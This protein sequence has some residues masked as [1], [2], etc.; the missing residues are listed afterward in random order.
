LPENKR[1]YPRLLAALAMFCH[2]RVW[3]ILSVALLLTA[4]CMQYITSHMAVSTDF[5]ALLSHKL[6]FARN[7][8]ALEK[9]FP[10]H[11]DTVLVVIDGD[12]ADVSAYAARTFTAW[13]SRH[14]HVTNQ[15]FDPGG[16][17]FFQRNGLL[18]LNPDELD[19]VSGRL[20]TMQPVLSQ[21]ARDTSLPGMTKLIGDAFD[22]DM[23][24]TPDKSVVLSLMFDAWRAAMSAVTQQRFF[25]FPW[26]DIM[27]GD[28]NIMAS[29]QHIIEVTPRMDAAAIQPA[30]QAIKAIQKA[31][32]ALGLTPDHG[33]RVRLTGS[34]M[35][36]YVQ[37]QG[38]MQAVGLAASLAGTLILLLLW[39]ALKSVRM[40][41][42]VTLTLVMSLIWTTAFALYA[43][44][45]LNIISISFAVLFIGMGV[46]FGIQFGMHC[47]RQSSRD[48]CAIAAIRHTASGQ[49]AAMTISATAAAAG[50]L[51]FTPTAYKGLADLGLIAGAGMALALAATLTVLPALMGWLHLPDTPHPVGASFDASEDGYSG[52]GHL[53]AWISAHARAITGA[54]IIIACM[55]LLPAMNLTF[56]F[57]P[58]HLLDAS[59]PAVKTFKDLARASKASPY[60]IEILAK[61]KSSAEKLA[62]SLRQQSSVA[63][64]VTLSSLIPEHQDEKLAAIEELT[65]L[66]PPFTLDVATYA[67]SSPV[68]IRAA[69]TRTARILDAYIRAHTD[70]SIA[71]H[72]EALSR[73]IRDFISHSSST[74]LLTLEKILMQGLIRQI[75]LLAVSL[76]PE[77][78][79]VDQLPQLLKQRFLTPGGGRLIQVYS[80]LNLDNPGNMERFVRQ[81]QRLAPQAS[82]DPVMMVAGGHAVALAFRQASVIAFVF[83]AILLAFSLKSVWYCIGVL[84]PLLLA[85]LLTAATMK[86][87]GISLNLANVIVAPLLAGLGVSYGIYMALRQRMEGVGGLFASATP[88]AILFSALTTL[89]SFGSMAISGDTAMTSLGVTLTIALS[90]VLVCVLI[91][92]PAL[93][94]LPS[95]F[96]PGRPGNP[97]VNVYPP[98]P[99]RQEAP[100]K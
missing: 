88:Q 20:I 78:I 15:F 55:A 28:A 85:T 8:A 46:D 50:F 41:L 30:A 74:R 66:L 89:C 58:L 12:T 99:A 54:S 86:I 24:D 7:H 65:M 70:S 97:C 25:V 11:N 57:N 31:I 5:D 48:I 40:L 43:T 96:I 77:T 68:A 23:F 79:T 56:D 76:S 19:A 61:N 47:R 18:Y 10:R 52:E 36:D 60:A 39:M 90:M 84:V 93:L 29:H 1:L 3:L 27:A 83:V 95:S 53:A 32:P 92:Q 82:G 59:E 4:G 44:A 64:V 37:L 34:A 73:G 21:L 72:A 91:I 16:S 14:P 87:F 9:A 45:P 51:A 6:P 67:P 13:L 38:S 42:A 69:L 26:R 22:Y 2:T 63:R 100:E 49:G 71:P 17:T 33:I 94:S 75:S 80:R 62:A 35:L 98:L 81:V